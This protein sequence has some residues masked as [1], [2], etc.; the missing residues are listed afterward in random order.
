MS[1]LLNNE[2]I[3]IFT[4]NKAVK[5]NAINVITNTWYN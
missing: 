3:G 2:I 4:K 5:I 1:G